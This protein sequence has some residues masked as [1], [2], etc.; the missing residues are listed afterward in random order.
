M[1]DTP[2]THVCTSSRNAVTPEH[3]ALQ[4]YQKRK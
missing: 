2:T 4:G 1:A 3:A